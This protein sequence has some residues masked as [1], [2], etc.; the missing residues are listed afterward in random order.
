[1]NILFWL[2]IWCII[3]VSIGVIFGSFIKITE[4]I[5]REIHDGKYEGLKLPKRGALLVDKGCCTGRADW[6]RPT[7]EAE[8]WLQINQCII[9]TNVGEKWMEGG[10]GRGIPGVVAGQILVY[11]VEDCV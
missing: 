6:E 11:R 4:V 8:I 10:Y 5:S 2:L 3:S 9:T 7:V 1:M